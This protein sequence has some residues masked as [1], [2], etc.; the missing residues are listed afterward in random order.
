MNRR[1]NAQGAAR[2]ERAV[3]LAPPRRW[4]AGC[5]VVGTVSG[6]VIALS[7]EISRRTMDLKEIKSEL[8]KLSELVGGWSGQR[9][10]SQLEHD[11]VLEK[12]RAVYEAPRFGPAVTG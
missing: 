3:P 10:V 11:L 1:R 6:A 2:P 12:L 8:R 7:A 9:P 4:I 5:A